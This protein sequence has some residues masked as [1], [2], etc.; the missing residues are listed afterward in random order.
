MSIGIH[1][2]YACSWRPIMGLFTSDEQAFVT[3]AAELTYCNP[4]L[5]QRVELEKQLLG[6]GYAPSL[7]TYDKVDELDHEHPNLSRIDERVD[8]VAGKARHRL[9]QDFTPSA[10]DWDVYHS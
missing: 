10:V 5:P 3:A 1:P 9:L 6:E 2:M 7:W 4:F 8:Q